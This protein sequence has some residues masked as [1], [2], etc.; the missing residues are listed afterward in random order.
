MQ[1]ITFQI[2]K[3]VELGFS[4]SKE[5]GQIVQEMN[6]STLLI[7]V[8]YNLMRLGLVDGVLDNLKNIGIE[9]SIFDD[10]KGEPTIRE[11]DQAIK[12]MNIGQYDGVVGI[13]GGS[14]LDTAK[15]FAVAGNINDS[16]REYI[17]EK[18]IKPGL[19]TIMIPTTSGTGSEATPN[20]IVKDEENDIKIGLI[21]PA[22]IP[23]IV[24]LDPELT[25]SLPAKVTAETGIDAFTHAIEC[26]I[27]NKAN[28]MSNLYALEAIHLISKYLVEAVKNGSNKK[29]R[30]NMLLGS[31]Y[32]GVAITNSGTG[33]VHALAYPLGGKYGVAHGLSNS[34]LLADVMEYNAKA[35]PEKFVKVAEMMELKTN[36]L[37]K[38]RIVDLVVDKIRNLTI[39]AGIKVGSLNIGGDDIVDLANSALT[40]QRLL[41]NNPRPIEFEDAKGI[42]E[43]VFLENT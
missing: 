9:Y 11:I 20:S 31:F 13:G 27:C 21:G 7:V 38:E 1:N 6:S 12:K 40:V 41:K 2:P 26:F 14:A 33:A 42:Y 30:Y 34:I 16:I 37:S 22:L 18:I 3:R 24:I 29:A 23:E 8:D 43:K 4:R 5:L 35:V 10:I 32:G 19:P 28:D 17:G 15:L 36:G 39:E 25:L